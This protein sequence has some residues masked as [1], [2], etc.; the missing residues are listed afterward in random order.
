MRSQHSTKS[1]IYRLR[2]GVQQ[3]VKHLAF[4]LC[5]LSVIAL[6]ANLVYKIFF[7]EVAIRVHEALALEY[8]GLIEFSTVIIIL[9]AMLSVVNLGLGLELVYMFGVAGNVQ[10]MFI[11]S[12][13][14]AVIGYLLIGILVVLLITKHDQ[15]LLKTSKGC[16]GLYANTA[17]GMVMTVI[18]SIQAAMVFRSGL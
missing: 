7:A 18:V 15:C 1:G 11:A 14:T 3:R 13:I 10:V 12:L 8:I 4:T 6:V 16:V 17:Y 9:Y 2:D 5:T